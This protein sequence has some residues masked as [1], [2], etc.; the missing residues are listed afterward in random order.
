MYHM[1]RHSYSQAVSSAPILCSSCSS[2]CFCS[3]HI[4]FLLCL[5][6][7]W[8]TSFPAFPRSLARSGD[9]L[10][11]GVPQQ[12]HSSLETFWRTSSPCSIWAYIFFLL[13]LAYIFFLLHLAYILFLLHLTSLWCVQVMDSLVVSLS[14]FTSPLNPL[15]FKP[16]VT[17]GENEKARI[18]TEAVFTVANR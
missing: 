10:A 8:R 11:G 5:M 17:F 15:A 3:I 2:L 7:L 9:K 18:A 14:K 16:V 1:V 4:F 13:H 12:V 6:S